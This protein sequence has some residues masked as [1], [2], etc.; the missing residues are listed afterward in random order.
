[1]SDEHRTFLRST[2]PAPVVALLVRLF[3]RRYTRE[4]APVWRKAG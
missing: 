4:V 1:M 2:V 3:G